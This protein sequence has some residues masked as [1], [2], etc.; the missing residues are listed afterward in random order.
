MADLPLAHQLLTASKDGSLWKVKAALQ[1]GADKDARNSE[2]GWTPLIV[3]A[4]EG[5]L[6]VCRYLLTEGCNKEAAGKARALRRL[7]CA[8]RS[9]ALLRLQPGVDATAGRRHCARRCDAG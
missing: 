3:A 5:H 7:R 6:D 4:N 8:L 9:W 2:T 1:E